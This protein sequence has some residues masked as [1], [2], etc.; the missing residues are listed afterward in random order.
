MSKLNNCKDHEDLVVKSM[1]LLLLVMDRVS[2][3]GHVSEVHE[4]F[5]TARAL[6]PTSAICLVFG[7]QKSRK[8]FC[9]GI[10]YRRWSH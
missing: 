7:L 6:G 10:V 4:S 5:Y 9:G 1:K 3:V 8:Q 2:G